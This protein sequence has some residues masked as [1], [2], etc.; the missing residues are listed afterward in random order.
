MLKLTQILLVVLFLF[1]S[2]GFI[3]AYF[4]LGSI[5][6]QNAVY[7]INNGYLPHEV[8]VLENSL[9]FESPDDNEIVFEGMLYDVIKK[10]NICGKTIYYCLRDD[11][12]NNLNSVLNDYLENGTEGSST[13]PVKNI[14][15][16]LLS[17]LLLPST[18][19]IIQH[20][21]IIEYCGFEPVSYNLTDKEVFTPPPQLG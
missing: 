14:L 2:C 21:F 12:E 13:A 15:S 18:D 20:S 11:K 8:V 10:E 5:Y 17:D 16:N 7:K 1:N 19:P 3:F 9:A 4:Q 6:K